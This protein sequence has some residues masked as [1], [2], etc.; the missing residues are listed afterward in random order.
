MEEWKESRP[1][2]W[3]YEMICPKCGFMYSPTK[4]QDGTISSVAIYKSCPQCGERLKDPS[5]DKRW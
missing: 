5:E 1:N 2:D 3:T 4:N